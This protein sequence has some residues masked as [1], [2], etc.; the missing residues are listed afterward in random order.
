[1]TNKTTSISKSISMLAL[2]GVLGMAITGVLVAFF[3][4]QE[5]RKDIRFTNRMAEAKIATL[6]IESH[7]NM[8]SRIARNIMLGSDVRKD[9]ARYDASIA[10]MEK[11]FVQLADS[12]SG[13]ADTRLIDESRR[14][15]MHYLKVAYAFCQEMETIP[16]TERPSHY[17]RFGQVATPAAEKARESFTEIV[18]LKDAE[19][20]TAV[21]AI[22]ARVSQIV[23]LSMVIS[24]LLALLCAVAAFRII[25]RIR[26]PLDEVI[27]YTRHIASGERSEI[28]ASRYPAELQQLTA[29]LGLMVQQMR[30]YTRGVLD[31]L[32]MPAML[33]NR[34]GEATWW[35]RELTTLSGTDMTFRDQTTPVPTVLNDAAAVELYRDA[36]RTD[37]AVEAEI[38][39]ASGRVGRMACT[40]FCD[41]KGRPIGT[42]VTGLD[43]TDLWL[44]KEEAQQQSRELAARA[45]EAEASGRLVFDTLSLMERD[46]DRT[47]GNADAQRDRMDGVALAVG[48]LDN[49]ILDVAKNAGQT[50]ELA[51]ATRNIAL[52]GAQIIQQSITAFGAVSRNADALTEDM[53]QLHKH[54]EDI[55]RILGVIND[56]ADQ[57][58]LL[59]LNAAIEA[60]RAG[61][62]GRGFAV[63]ADEVRKLAEKTMH[64]TTEVQVFV[65]AIGESVR[66]SQ[67]TVTTTGLEL[68]SASDLVSQAET[69]L[70]QIVEQAARSADSMRSIARHTEEQ[71][72]AS[73]RVKDGTDEVNRAAAAASETMHAL[74]GNVRKLEDETGKL[75]QIIQ[76]MAK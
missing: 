7:F 51:D 40:P 29:S 24:C 75:E 18:R 72:A 28:D 56:I 66:Q 49:A 3:M 23:T 58:N 26:Q 32:P 25:R 67:E 47:A 8:V 52:E 12:A 27:T 53:R 59:A 63:V 6:N 19:Y 69:H 38:H 65:K 9:L 20:V 36:R 43:M 4:G 50:V 30:A 70:G 46:L 5:M 76:F 57:T 1:M 10:I 48:Q 13:E 45:H 31:S 42:L 71:A 17:A 11:A 74:V 61:E 21:T 15:V 22:D 41:D 55:G 2:A 33:V 35:N 44:K 62:S 39:F 64:A 73:N 34:E 14:L 54:A 60:A 68:R 16:Q 37:Q